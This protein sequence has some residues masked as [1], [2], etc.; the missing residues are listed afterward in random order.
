MID[1]LVIIAFKSAF[2]FLTRL[3]QFKYLFVYF[4]VFLYLHNRNLKVIV[5]YSLAAA[6]VQLEKL[7]IAFDFIVYFLFSEKSNLQLSFVL[8]AILKDPYVNIFLQKR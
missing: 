3:I 8:T 5:P 2:F 6:F 1:K 7:K 4:N